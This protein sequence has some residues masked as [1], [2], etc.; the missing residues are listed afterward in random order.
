MDQ[1]VDE[2]QIEVE[3]EVTQE[4]NNPNSESSFGKKTKKSSNKT[5]DSFFMKR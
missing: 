4:E 5:I 3:I 2:E 1:I